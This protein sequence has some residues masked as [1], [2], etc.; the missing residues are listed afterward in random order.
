VEI[1]LIIAAVILLAPLVALWVDDER[2]HTHH[3]P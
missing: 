2:E 1:I 3:T